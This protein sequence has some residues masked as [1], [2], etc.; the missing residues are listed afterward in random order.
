V[1]VNKKLL[2][3]NKKKQALEDE[4]EYLIEEINK[5]YNKKN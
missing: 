1:K 4:K 2:Q 3:Y 5:E